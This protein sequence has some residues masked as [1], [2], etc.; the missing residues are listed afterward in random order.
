VW[1]FGQ[2]TNGKTFGKTRQY[3]KPSARFFG[4]LEGPVR[5]APTC[6]D[7]HRSKG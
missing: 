5:P 6:S 7:Q 4:N 3:G 1:E 2:M